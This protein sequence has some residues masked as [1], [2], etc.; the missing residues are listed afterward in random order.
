MESGGGGGG[1]GSG[2]FDLLLFVKNVSRRLDP[3]GIVLRLNG[4][5][6]EVGG[7]GGVDSPRCATERRL[8]IVS[9][10]DPH[11]RSRK[12]QVN[13]RFQMNLSR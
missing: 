2:T 9:K 5:R 11:F 1:G 7:G 4:K 12:F 8:K 3:E 6:P 13:E 10:C